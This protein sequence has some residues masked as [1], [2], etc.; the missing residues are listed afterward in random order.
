MFYVDG[1]QPWPGLGKALWVYPL[2]LALR[3][4]KPLSLPALG[5]F[6]VKALKTWTVSGAQP[7]RNAQ[8]M[9]QHL[10]A[11]VKSSDLLPVNHV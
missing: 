5:A 8:E 7:P 1:M 4:R 11:Q 6:P 3:E 10:L 2:H 9:T